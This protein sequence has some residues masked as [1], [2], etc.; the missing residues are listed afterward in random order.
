MMGNIYAK[1]LNDFETARK[2]YNE[3]LSIDPNDYIALTSIGAVFAN[4]GKNPEAEQYLNLSYSIKN[5]YPNTLYGLGLINKV[6]RNYLSAFDYAVKALKL[7]D[8]S[9]TLNKVSGSLLIDIANLYSEENKDK[10]IYQKYLDEISIL[11][12][13]EIK[14]EIDNTISLPAKTEVAEKYKRDYHLI[15]HKSNIPAIHHFILHELVHLDL[16]AKARLAGNYKDFTYT[17]DSKKLF[18]KDTEPQVAKLKQLGFSEKDTDEYL[19]MLYRGLLS[20]L[21]NNPIDLIVEDFIYSNYL[22]NR[23]IQLLGL[24]Y[25]QEIAI[26]GAN[27]EDMKNLIP[28]FVRESNIVMNLVHVNQIKEFF[29][30]DISKKYKDGLQYQAQANKLYN[31]FKYKQKSLKPGDEYDLVNYFGKE[32]KLTKY[33]KFNQ[34]NLNTDSEDILSKIS[35]D[36]LN[37]EPESRPEKESRISFEPGSAKSMAVTMYCLSAIQYFEGKDTSLIRKITFEIAMLGSYGLDPNDNQKHISLKTIPGKTFTPLQLLA[38][39]YV[40]FQI[41]DPTVDTGLDFQDEYELAKGMN[42]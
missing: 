23:P 25:I 13:K 12:G 36:P 22:E 10:I 21:F 37:I 42:K 38:Y 2:F 20:Q 24:L 11:L 8:V 17:E 40:G 14:I 15:K 32:L 9:T 28:V 27:K 1:Y 3:T 7:S 19:N 16:I 31:N 6:K 5:D 30:I 41:I 35:K 4:Y 26:E 29:G 33:Y 18:Y 34:E 39:E